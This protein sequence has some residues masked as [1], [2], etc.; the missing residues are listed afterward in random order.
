MFV[1]I[2]YYIGDENSLKLWV[3]AINQAI[4][5]KR[6]F[7]SDRVNEKKNESNIE[8]IETLKHEEIKTSWE[9]LGF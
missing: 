3:S 9:P 7:L 4:E 6:S 2:L 5:Y 8:P 1:F